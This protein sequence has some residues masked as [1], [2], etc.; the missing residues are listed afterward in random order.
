MGRKK[1]I[2]F[3]K[4]GS[5]LVNAL[6]I[7]GLSQERFA[8]KIGISRRTLNNWISRDGVTYHN[9]VLIE[10]LLHD[11]GKQLHEVG[12]FK[13]K[14]NTFRTIGKKIAIEVPVIPMK[15]YAQYVDEFYNEASDITFETAVLE[16]D[17]FGKGD[18]LAFDISGDSMNGGLINDTPDGARVLARQIGQHLWR[19]GLNQ[20]KYGHILITN[21]NILFKDITAFSK[22][23]M[24]ITL[25]SRN[26]SPEYADFDM[27]LGYRES[28]DHIQQIFKVTKRFNM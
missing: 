24:T 11:M 27:A 4:N 10:S 13:T 28:E 21:K 18:Y 9:W 20:S 7:S 1:E 15:A 26:S 8:E 19:G 22:K 17:H 14:N 16:V 2:N 12:T 3:H 25:H 5:D 23:D 6:N